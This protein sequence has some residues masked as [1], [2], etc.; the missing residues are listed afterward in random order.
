METNKPRIA[1]VTGLNGQD[2]SYLAE[3]LL[4]RGYFV[5]G[6]IR[7][8]SLMNT[9]RIDHLIHHPNFSHSYGDV[10]DSVSLY[11]NL[12]EIIRKHGFDIRLE[13]YH[14]AAQSHVR[15]SFDL[16]EYTADTDAIGTLKV[17]EAARI[18]RDT[19]HLSKDNLR[20]YIACTSEMFGDVLETPQT[21]KTPFNPQSP[22][23]CAKVFSFY[24][25][26]NYREAYDMYISSGILFNHES[27]RRGHNFVTRKITIG[28]GKILRG[29]IE[30]IEM[31]NIDSI[32]D[33]GHAKDYV[34]A[35]RLMLQPEKADDFVIATNETHSVR[36]FIEKSFALK[37]LHITWYSLENNEKGQE[38]QE[39]QENQED[40][41][42][43]VGVDQNGIVRITINPKYFRPTEVAF[44][45]GD[46][47]KAFN[48]LQ[49]KPTTSFDA[50]VR[51]MVETDTQ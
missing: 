8:M 17:L 27:P 39:N 26:K 37:G 6:I 31:G 1:F 50:L 30:M 34:E 9:A 2:G 12:D 11:R 44:L 41:Q 16:P 38:N 51:E 14:L 48:T 49:W 3:N 36:E 15:V 24:I 10:C 42:N 18:I 45:Q 20:I 43:E 7:R 19:H 4:E 47:T 5:Y 25:G 13:I 35:M 29:E 23:A 46:A 22:Y 33:W 21:E 28:L 40:K 32:R